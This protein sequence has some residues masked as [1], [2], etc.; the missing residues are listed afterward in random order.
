MNGFVRDSEPQIFHVLHR[1]EEFHEW[2][3]H[4]ITTATLLDG[5]LGALLR[6]QMNLNRSLDGV[7]GRKLDLL[8]QADCLHC[9]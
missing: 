8:D 3:Y 6:S 4:A 2:I 1:R 7:L 5:P 9:S